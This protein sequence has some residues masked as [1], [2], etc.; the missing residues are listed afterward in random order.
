MTFTLPFQDAVAI[1]FAIWL[2]LIVVRHLLGWA[3]DALMFYRWKRKAWPKR[4]K[5]R[6]GALP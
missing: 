6:G 1:G 2:G 3:R 4:I 5:V